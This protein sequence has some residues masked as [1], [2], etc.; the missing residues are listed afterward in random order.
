[1]QHPNEKVTRASHS[2]L[3]SF[4]SSVNVANQDEQLA[5]KEQLI[6][7]YMRRALEVYTSALSVQFAV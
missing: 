2:V 5:L 4:L 6:F 3:V 7:Y 1:M